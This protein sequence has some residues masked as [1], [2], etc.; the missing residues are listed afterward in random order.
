MGLIFCLLKKNNEI[1]VTL[2]FIM[3]YQ[4]MIMPIPYDLN[5][6]FSQGI[7]FKPTPSFFYLKETLCYMR[8]ACV[9]CY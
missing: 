9:M 5:S 1:K 7:C 8:K 6:A 3:E 4:F 2:G